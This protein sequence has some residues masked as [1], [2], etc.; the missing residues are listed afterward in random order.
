MGGLKTL[1]LAGLVLAG[2]HQAAA[3]TLPDIENAEQAVVDAWVQTPITFRRALFV[4]G[5][6]EGFGIFEQRADA[7][8]A[9]G[10]P[11]VVYAE[12]AG[13]LWQDNGDGT[14]NF[15]FDIDLLVK[16][17]D[18]EIIGGKEK[19]QQ[20]VLTSH[21]RN[22]EFMLILTLTL[23]GAPPGDYVV[24]YVTHDISSDKVGKISLPFT[25]SG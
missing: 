19:F 20:T 4:A 18:G 11:I 22:R 12:P 13:Y 24:E 16:S 2:V 15:G 3:Q 9:P 25:I 5:H 8:F 6:P 10:E 17:S 1:L 7:V 21:S 14:Y 23:T